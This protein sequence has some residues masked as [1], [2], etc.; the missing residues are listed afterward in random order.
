MTLYPLG[1]ASVPMVQS[2]GTV[3]APREVPAKALSPTSA[4]LP[5]KLTEE[6]ELQPKK[7]LAPTLVREV[8]DKSSEVRPVPSKA[9]PPMVSRVDGKFTEARVETPE[10]MPS[11]IV[12]RLVAERLT[13][14]MTL[15]M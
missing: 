6:R 5:G 13:E 14:V 8:L 12:V 2:K 15:F 9:Y 1:K 4:R 10:K 11:S 3:T 7:L